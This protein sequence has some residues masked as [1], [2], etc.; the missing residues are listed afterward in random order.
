MTNDFFEMCDE[1]LIG[2]S[3]EEITLANEAL[4]VLKKKEL[5]FQELFKVLDIT[6]ALITQCKL[7][8]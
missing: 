1:M 3:K 6:K 8:E 4:D 7:S 2:A 5:T